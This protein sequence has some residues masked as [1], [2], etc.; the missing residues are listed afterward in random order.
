MDTPLKICLPLQPNSTS[1]SNPDPEE[2][3]TE[4]ITSV[5]TVTDSSIT[6]SNSIAVCG[7][8]LKGYEPQCLKRA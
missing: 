4:E 6:S 7:D 2:L 5:T 3:L 1:G 8:V